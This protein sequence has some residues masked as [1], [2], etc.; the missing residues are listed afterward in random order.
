MST[1]LTKNI[2]SLDG[3]PIVFES[4]IANTPSG[5]ITST[6]V[7]AAL[8]ELDSEK[9]SRS[10]LLAATGSSL[11]GY[12]STGTGAIATTVEQELKTQ[13]NANNYSTIQ[14]AITAAGA[15]GSVIIPAS[16]AGTDAYTTDDNIPITDLRHKQTGFWSRI[17]PSYPV[18]KY[19][20]GND[21]VFLA[22]GPADL[23]I[24]HFHVEA[25]TTVTL[26][27][28]L[29]TNVPIS[30]VTCGNKRFPADSGT[31]GTE[32]FSEFAQL[33]IGRETANEEQVNQGSWSIV[34]AT[35][36]NITCTKTHTGITDIDQG[37]STL[38]NSQDL[39]IGSNAVKPGQNTTYSAPLRVKDFGGR[40]IAKIPSNIDDIFP[41]SMW[42]WGAVQSGLYGV[43]RDLRYKQSLSTSKV[44][45][46]NFDNVEIASLNNAGA[47]KALGGLA[48]GEGQMTLDGVNAEVKV[49]RNVDGRAITSPVDCHVVFQNNLD[50]LNPSLTAGSLLLAS[51]IV[52]SAINFAPQNV[53]SGSLTVNGLKL[54]TGFGC[55]NKAPQAAAV[56]GG[57]LAGVIAALVA[58]GILLS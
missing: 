23:Y 21:A 6:N 35:H 53:W 52:A 41:H 17:G 10:T 49:G 19:P 31:G 56:S 42:Q 3:T 1:L 12:V 36:I 26:N 33:F 8:A 39:Y 27:V 14:Q 50:S 54:K 57:T 38:L 44:I 16:Y 58:N 30:A 51:S 46:G 32:M 22:R 18:S 11:V 29:N 45:W 2:S 15:S 7:H 5:S 34:D 48:A 47:Y 24:E 4:G 37:G 20:F 9:L 13:I 25:T 40:I 43:N 28:G 55:N